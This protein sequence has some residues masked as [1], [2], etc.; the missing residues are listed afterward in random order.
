MYASN[1]SRAASRGRV[2]RL[3]T[4]WV[5]AYSVV[6]GRI[7]IAVHECEYFNDA[8]VVVQQVRDKLGSSDSQFWVFVVDAFEQPADL[9]RVQALVDGLLVRSIILDE[10]A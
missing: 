6:I 5:G 3:C 2:L 7:V 4:V 1:C 10:P 9:V 8:A